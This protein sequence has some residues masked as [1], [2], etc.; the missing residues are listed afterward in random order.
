MSRF[1]EAIELFGREVISEVDIAVDMADA[2]G[3]YTLFEDLNMFDHADCVKFL[4]LDYE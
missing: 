4:Y 2:D 1:E 3:A